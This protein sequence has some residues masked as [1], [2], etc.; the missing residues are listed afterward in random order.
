MVETSSNLGVNKAQQ[1]GT[2]DGK[3]IVPVGIIPW[4]L[5]QQDTKYKEVSSLQIC[6]E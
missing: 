4:T 6:R 5:F 1:V 2:H 3:I